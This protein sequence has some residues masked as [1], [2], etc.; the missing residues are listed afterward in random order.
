MKTCVAQGS[1]REQGFM[2]KIEGIQQL[3]VGPT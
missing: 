3:G 2:V 1:L